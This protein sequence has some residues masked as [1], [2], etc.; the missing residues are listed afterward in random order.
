MQEAVYRSLCF[1][2]RDHF[3][4]VQD[5]QNTDDDKRDRQQLSH[6]QRH[7]GLESFLDIFGILD[8][9][10][11]SVDDTL[12]TT[13]HGSSGIVS[14]D[15]MTSSLGEVNLHPLIINIMV[16]G[17]SGITST[18]HTSDE[19]IWIITTYLL[20]QLPFDFLGDNT[21][22]LCHDVRIRMRSHRTTYNIKSILW[23][24]APVTDRL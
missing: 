17:T 18:A 9:E 12:G 22:H 14:V 16:D 15:A 23:M 7:V 8:E 2:L 11:G 1:L 10:A 21:L 3:L 13:V 20:L 5:A 19:I 4:C 6:I 24:A